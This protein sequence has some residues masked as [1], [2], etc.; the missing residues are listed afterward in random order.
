LGEY[1]QCGYYDKNGLCLVKTKELFNKRFYC[2]KHIELLK[3]YD[4]E[5]NKQV[6]ILQEKDKSSSSSPHTHAS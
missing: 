4:E 3:G 6:K 5:V 2:D 1:K